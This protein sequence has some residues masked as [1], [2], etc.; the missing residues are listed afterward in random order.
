MTGRPHT[1][2]SKKGRVWTRGRL[3][4][5][6]EHDAVRPDARLHAQGPLLHESPLEVRRSL[7][8]LFLWHPLHL[9][10]IAHRVANSLSILIERVPVHLPR[11][12][13]PLHLLCPEAAN[14]Y[15]VTDSLQWNSRV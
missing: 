7:C 12:C 3:G 14:L 8:P 2:P 15:C 10:S 5:S 11:L 4:C 1:F 9:I 13:S 6:P